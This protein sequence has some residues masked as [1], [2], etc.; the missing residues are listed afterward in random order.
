MFFYVRIFSRDDPK[1]T[2]LYLACNVSMVTTQASELRLKLAFMCNVKLGL[3]YRFAGRKYG[4]LCACF[5]KLRGK[6]CL[7]DKYE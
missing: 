7:D 2:R 3:S 4:L 5:A 1:H 6:G